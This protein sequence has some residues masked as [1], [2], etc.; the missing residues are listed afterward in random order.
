MIAIMIQNTGGPSLLV[1]T[2]TTLSV[3]LPIMRG[4][5]IQYGSLNIKRQLE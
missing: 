3:A 2:L 5:S 1:V 4:K